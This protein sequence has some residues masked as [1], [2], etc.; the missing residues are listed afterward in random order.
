MRSRKAASGASVPVALPK[1]AI[2]PAAQEVDAAA[3]QQQIAAA[4]GQPVAPAAMPAQPPSATAPVPFVCEDD[5]RTAIRQQRKI[6]IG[7]RTIVTPAARDLADAHRV[8][9]ETPWPAR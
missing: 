1:R 7:E 2:E 4:L 8:F 6:L 5:V 3:V 9:V